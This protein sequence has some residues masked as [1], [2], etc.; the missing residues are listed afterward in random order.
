MSIEAL[1]AWMGANPR[2]LPRPHPPYHHI[3]HT[4]RGLSS[5]AVLQSPLLARLLPDSGWHTFSG[6][7]K[8][9]DARYQSSSVSPKHFVSC[10]ADTALGQK[11]KTTKQIVHALILFCLIACLFILYLDYITYLSFASTTAKESLIHACTHPSTH[12]AKMMI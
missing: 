12:L 2:P 5:L 7:E 3:L 4:Q 10:T 11:V 8:D 9:R 1:N 6:G